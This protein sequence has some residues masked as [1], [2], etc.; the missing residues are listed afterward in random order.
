MSNIHQELIGTK[1][2]SELIGES[3]KNTIRRVERNELTPVTKLPGLRGAYLFNRSDIDALLTLPATVGVST[4]N[5]APT[6]HLAPVGSSPEVEP[7]GVS[8]RDGSAS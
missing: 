6:A 5:P 1:E 2:A 7:A 8:F 3:V 4:P